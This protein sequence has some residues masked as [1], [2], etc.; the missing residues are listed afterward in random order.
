MKLLSKGSVK[1]LFQESE[2]FY[3]QFSDRYSIFDWGEMP[4][5]LPQKGKALA[6]M[7]C[8][9]FRYLESEGIKT[10]FVGG[11]DSDFNLLKSSNERVTGFQFR[12]ASV[13]RPVT[14]PTG[15][16]QYSKERGDYF[17]PLEVIFRFG[18]PEGSS[19]A[20]EFRIGTRFQ[21]PLVEFTTKLEVQDRKLC[22]EEA[23]QISGLTESEFLNLK[24]R[25]VEIAYLVE[26]LLSE[27]GLTLWDGKFEFALIENE[28]IL[29]DALG[30]DELRLSYENFPVSK[31][32]LRKWYRSSDWYK[33]VQAAKAHGGLNWKESVKSYPKKLDIK[34]AQCISELYQAL[35]DELN[36]KING[37][38]VFNN[39]LSMDQWL[40][41]YRELL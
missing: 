20:Q 39:N 35:A 25:T 17:I 8:C 18:V 7:A 6:V 23:F 9:F 14:S 5:H 15:E 28:I 3:F 22:D 10:H 40:L 12:P 1:D 33:E 38:S 32:L 11:V 36:K 19:K 2:N 30:P 21:S 24:E 41:K 37:I 27:M 26:K 29:V 4:D 16:Y 34:K 31:E 13:K